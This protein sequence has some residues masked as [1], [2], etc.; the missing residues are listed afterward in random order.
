MGEMDKEFETAGIGWLRC[1]GSWLVGGRLVGD[2][3]PS[4]VHLSS[5]AEPGRIYFDQRPSECFDVQVAIKTSLDIFYFHVQFD[6]SAT[7]SVEHL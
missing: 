3:F 5:A 7:F 4:S 2:H 1:L 6:L